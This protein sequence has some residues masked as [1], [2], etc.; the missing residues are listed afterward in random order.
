MKLNEQKTLFIKS[1]TRYETI[2]ITLKTKVDDNGRKYVTISGLSRLKRIDPGGL[3]Y[4]IHWLQ[5]QTDELE[6]KWS[7]TWVVPKLNNPQLKNN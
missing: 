5:E 3:L 2:K 7:D 1:T 4:L 6:I